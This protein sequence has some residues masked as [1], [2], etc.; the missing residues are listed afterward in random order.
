MCIDLGTILPY[1]LWMTC[2]LLLE[3]ISPPVRG[4][5]TFPRAHAALVFKCATRSRQRGL[6]NSDS[7]VIDSG[8]RYSREYRI[9]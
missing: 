1:S 2:R 5:L 3:D 8:Q 9:F 7:P 4:C 6:I